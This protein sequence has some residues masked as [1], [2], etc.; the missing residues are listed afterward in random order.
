[1]PNLKPNL[2]L[3]IGHEHDS[4][5]ALFTPV[6]LVFAANEERFDR[7]K[8]T[9][10]LPEESLRSLLKTV[11]CNPL[12]ITEVAIGSRMNSPTV[13]EEWTKVPIFYKT[14]FNI[15]S[16]TRL[17]RIL[18]GNVFC[19]TTITSIVAFLTNPLRLLRLRKLVGR[20]GIRARFHIYDHHRVHAVSALIG[21]GFEDAM[22]ITLDAQGDGLCSTIY[23]AT[24]NKMVLLKRVAFFHSPGNYYSYITHMFGFKTGREG[25]VTGLAAYG[26]PEETADIFRSRIC[27]D[28]RKMTF[29]NKGKY[30]DAEMGYLRRCLAGKKREDIAAGLQKVTEEVVTDYIKCAIKKYAGGRARLA[31]AGGVFA[32]VKLNQRIAEL[33]EV[34]KIFIYPHMGDGGMAAGAAMILGMEKGWKP[35]G[36]L[37]HCYLGPE[38]SEVEIEEA[39]R[40]S[41]LKYSRPDNLVAELADTLSRGE[42]VA[43]YRGGMEYGPRALGNRSIIAEAIDP[44]VNDWLNKRLKRSEFMPFAP[45]L[46]N[47]DLSLYFSGYEKCE[48]ALEFMTITLNVL[49]R[50]VSEAP[51]VV[52]VDGTARPQVVKKEINPFVWELLDTYG[53]RT[54]L[55]VLINTSYNM[56]EEPIVCTPAEAIRAFTIGGLNVLAIGPYIV[57][58]Q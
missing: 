47:E 42:I 9:K 45:I 20:H 17:D 58:N 25:K 27:F 49:P 21:S 19:A 7:Q 50:A 36:E 22:I 3:G 28:E 2:I 6:G 44:N 51:A 1:M 13:V 57:R 37:P 39:L 11:K 26:Q 41:G 5:I 16:I 34:E 12:S 53:E 38:F 31:L 54:G 56:H 33:P 32:N 43:I 35:P 52:H 40:E 15:L 29:V 48:K 55:R 4:G 10:A 23:K 46:K 30:R 24:G 8:F 14:I 18:F